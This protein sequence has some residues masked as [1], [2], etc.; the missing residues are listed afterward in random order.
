MWI[1]AQELIKITGM[2][3]TV[4]GIAYKAKVE[5]WERRKVKG[6]KK[7]TYEY[8]ISSLPIFDQVRI[9]KSQKQLMADNLIIDKL[10]PK[11]KNT[12]PKL[13]GLSMNKQ[14]INKKRKLKL[15]LG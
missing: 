15:K 11:E 12:V 7:V 9:L 4:Q 14:P 1:T 3:D 8:N 6:I 13:Y 10:K 2:P 5:N